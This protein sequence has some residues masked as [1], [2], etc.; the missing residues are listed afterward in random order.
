MTSDAT[1]G[2]DEHAPELIRSPTAAGSRCGSGSS[3]NNPHAGFGNPDAFDRDVDASKWESFTLTMRSPLL[4]QRIEELSG[5]LPGTG[6]LMTFKDSPWLMSLVVPHG[7]HFDGQDEDVCTAWGY[8]LF[9][10][11]PGAYV[12]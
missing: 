11:T 10:D 6:A 12:P 4:L 2:D 9:L 8:G 7:P 5:N 1:Y 3:P